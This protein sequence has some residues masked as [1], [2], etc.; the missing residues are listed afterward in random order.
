MRDG[1]A[2]GHDVLSYHH[3]NGS[4]KTSLAIAGL[5]GVVGDF[6]LQVHDNIFATKRLICEH[7]NKRFHFPS[8]PRSFSKMA[9]TWQD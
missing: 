4:L 8:G 3:R 5:M 9:A 1:K 6:A 7:G 2:Y